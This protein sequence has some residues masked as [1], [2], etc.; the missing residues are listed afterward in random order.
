MTESQMVSLLRIVSDVAV[1]G[2]ERPEEAV[3]V[4]TGEAVVIAARA[5]QAMTII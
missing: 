5:A 4:R 2:S 1:V 3:A